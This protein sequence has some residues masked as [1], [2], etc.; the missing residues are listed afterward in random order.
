[1]ALLKGGAPFIAGANYW[2]SEDAIRMWENWDANIVDRDFKLLSDHG[3]QYL[4]VF[5]V[6]PVFQPLKAIWANAQCYE[7]RMMPGESPLP[8]TEAGQAG[9]SEEACGHFEEFCRLADKYH[10]K[11]IVGLLTGHMSFRF[12]APDAFEGR[13]FLGDPTLIKWEIR[14]VKYFVKRFQNA[15]A[16]LAW[17]LGN[18]CNGYGG[19]SPDQSYVWT[20]AITSAI[21][22][23]DPTR[24]VISGFD[25]APKEGNGAF[26]IKE[27]GELTDILTT[28]PYHIFSGPIQYDPITTIR[29]CIHPVVVNTVYS[30]LGNKPCFVEE[31]GSIG[32]VNCS[33]KTEA[34]FLR[35]SLFSAWAHNCNGYFWWC[36][37]DQGQLDYAP[38]DWNNLGSDYGLFRADGSAKPVAE[39]MKNF[40]CFLKEFPY[41]DLPEHL[42][43]GVCILSREQTDSK[44]VA[45]AAFILA[46]Q[47]GFDITFAYAEDKLPDADLYLL[48]SV[49]S[50]KPIFL[51]RLRE[52]LERVRAGATLYISTDQMFRRLPELTGLTIAEREKTDVER[53]MLGND[54]FE[55]RDTW[56]YEIESIADTCTVLARTANGTPFYVFNSYG[57]GRI[58]Y[59][60]YKPELMLGKTIA[61]FASDKSPY[62]KFY[63]SLPFQSKRVVKSTNPLILTT[64]H[65]ADDETHIVIA[66]NYGHQT[67]TMHLEIADGWEI[68]KIYYGNPIIPA[69][70]VCI[71]EIKKQKA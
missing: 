67:G 44:L 70:D 14:F 55:M 65:I 6:W 59:M 17:D 45:N 58:Y 52:L 11:L 50:T 16:I 10:I 62:Y 57:K 20:H 13:N 47:A 24:P 56:K 28:H 30:C 51:H 34:R 43:E 9:V 36:A 25:N 40:H 29:P 22:A 54:H 69:N 27:T 38:Y 48:P 39:E 4:R 7:Y 18:E 3:I 49:T 35:T 8:D 32:Y 66:I 41:A 53:V 12:Y 60:A 42:T 19:I 63:E 33:Q 26:N 23:G 21:R 61:P 64:E 2:S 31:I 37:F 71:A 5:L 46:K 15:N 68:G 1:M